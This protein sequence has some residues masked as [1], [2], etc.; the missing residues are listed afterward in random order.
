M[1]DSGGGPEPGPSQG[2]KPTKEQEAK[3][4]DSITDTGIGSK[5]VSDIVDNL[6]MTTDENGVTTFSGD[7]KSITDSDPWTEFDPSNP[8]LQTG[9]YVPIQFPKDCAGKTVKLTGLTHTTEVVLTEDCL[10]IVR[11]EGVKNLKFTAEI[12]GVVYTFDLTGLVPVGEKA[13]DSSKEDYGR[14]GK[15]TDF[16]DNFNITW[17]E[18]KGEATGTIKYHEDIEGGKVFAGN[19]FP[20]P[21]AEWFSG[22]NKS[23]GI[24]SPRIAKDKDWILSVKS[25]DTHVKVIYN[26]LTVMDIDLSKMTL[27]SKDEPK[28]E[29]KP[30]PEPQKVGEQAISVVTGEDTMDD[31]ITKADDLVNGINISWEETTGTVTG[32]LKF[33]EFTNGKFGGDLATGHYLPIQITGWDGKVIDV[34][35]TSK[36][37][38]QDNRWIIRVDDVMKASKQIKIE[39]EG[40]LIATLD[41]TSVVLDPAVGGQAIKVADQSAHFENMNE[42]DTTAKFIDPDVTIS[43]TGNKGEVT[44][45]VKDYTFTNG[46]FA[47]KPNGHYLPIVIKNHDGE[48][49]KG[50]GSE[51]DEPQLIES[52]WIIRVDDFINGS[53][54]A[55]LYAND[56]EIGELS[57]NGMTLN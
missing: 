31:F 28:P 37:S 33:Y 21:L 52:N 2:S 42:G 9:H 18:E 3:A 25:L 22:V 43:W 7:V 44:G 38:V 27:Q 24:L 17:T 6:E 51:G 39:S 16:L 41:L 11:L 45:N 26:E 40:T 23:V 29:P 13:W 35:T 34:T 54:Y 8:E 46:H 49:I 36:K 57:F 14:F 19:H 47:R 55:K 56:V 15:K 5:Q 4:P 48:T 20:V 10:L 30:E 50:T 53:K 32:N 1:S 12:D